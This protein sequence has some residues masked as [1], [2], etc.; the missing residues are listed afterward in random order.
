MTLVG[1]NHLALQISFAWL[2]I[3]GSWYCWILVLFLKHRREGLAKEGRLLSQ[4]LPP[5]DEL[6]DVLVQIPVF[7]EGDLVCRL[8][9]AIAE[10]DW[11]TDRLHVQILD[12]SHDGSLTFSKTALTTLRQQ[13]IDATVLH[14]PNRNGFKAGALAAGLEISDHEFVAV[15]DADY[16]PPK[17]FLKSCIRPLLADSTIAFVQSRADFL[18]AKESLV[19]RIQQ[20]LL[21]AHYAIEQAARSWSGH[22]MPFNGTCGV[23]RRVAIDE[24]GGW[25]GDTLTEDLDL[26]YRAQLL[27]WRSS[28]LTTV[29]VFG[30]LPA[31]LRT[32][33]QQQFRW[34]KGVA[35]VARKV[36]PRVASSH[37]GFSRK[38]MSCLHLGSALLGPMTGLI[39]VS[40]VIDLTF[41]RGLT[42]G[43]ALLAIIFALELMAAE[44]IVLLSQRLVRSANVF[45]EFVKMQLILF[46]L[47]YVHFVNSRANLEAWLGYET[48]FVRTPKPQKKPWMQS[49]ELQPLRIL[50][51]VDD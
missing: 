22:I 19:T 11:P 9:A 16:V 20:R 36:L 10:F 26:S 2:C 44:S 21:D 7:N 43:T 27:G 32:W 31:N 15:F 30:E 8:A 4:A 50:A 25:Q 42:I 14:R 48:E 49:P 51:P 40:G 12:D 1:L 37:L 34:R 17:D 18:N 45:A 28:F 33:L 41:G 35:E 39:L 29:V 47:G 23:W 24:A 13:N 5:D 46:A 38:L 6:P 3:I